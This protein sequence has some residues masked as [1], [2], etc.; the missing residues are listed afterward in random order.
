MPFIRTDHN[1]CCFTKFHA[2]YFLSL[3]RVHS[4]EEHRSNFYC[5]NVVRAS[6]RQIKRGKNAPN[7]HEKSRHIF[8]GNRLRARDTAVNVKRTKMR[9]AFGKIQARTIS[10]VCFCALCCRQFP[11]LPAKAEIR[12]HERMCVVVF[13]GD[14]SGRIK[15]I[16]IY[17]WR[18]IH[19]QCLGSL[20]RQLIHDSRVLFHITS[21]T[22]SQIQAFRLF[23]VEFPN[24]LSGECFFFVVCTSMCISISYFGSNLCRSDALT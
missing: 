1:V 19:T 3:G 16:V 17:V 11:M 14:H 24:L 12:Q 22:H 6:L 8:I 15:C 23:S 7:A 5:Q 18:S 10:I 9:C 13:L 20:E 2:R 4:T 21:H